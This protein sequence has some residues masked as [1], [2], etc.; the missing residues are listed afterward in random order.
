MT[1]QND[2]ECN[3]L[4]KVNEIDA[5]SANDSQD[6]DSTGNYSRKIKEE[7]LQKL[8][9]DRELR[10]M[11]ANKV[12][13]FICVWSALL[14]FIL[15]LAGFKTISIVTFAWVPFYGVMKANF[16][17]SFALSDNVIMTLLATSFIEVLGL[18]HFVMRYLFDGKKEQAN[19]SLI[20][21]FFLTD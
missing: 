1:E 16:S 20:N 11:Y 2:L 6:P 9:D 12:F 8:K 5:I 19:K 14:F 18:F 17:S 13:W 3:L 21:K 4:Y 15:F 10:K 7:E